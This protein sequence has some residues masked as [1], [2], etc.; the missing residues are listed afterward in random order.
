[1]INTGGHL[2]AGG[3]KSENRKRIQKRLPL[4]KIVSK[5]VSVENGEIVVTI[6]MLEMCQ[7]ILL[8]DG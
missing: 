6:G 4:M 7:I 2:L 3:Y 1:V 5:S 8:Q